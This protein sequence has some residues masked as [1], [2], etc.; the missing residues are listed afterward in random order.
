MI[1]RAPRAPLGMA[2]P[3]RAASDVGVHRRILSF[4]FLDA[5]VDPLGDRAVSLRGVMALQP[6]GKQGGR[7]VVDGGARRAIVDAGKSLLAVGV[8]GADGEF[9]AGDAVEVVDEEH[10]LIGKGIVG[11]DAGRLDEVAGR[12]STEVGGAVIHRDDLVVLAT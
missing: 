12:H 3:G 4:P 9:G 10:R 5:E 6:E 11:V 1:A 8:V 2:Q 7:V